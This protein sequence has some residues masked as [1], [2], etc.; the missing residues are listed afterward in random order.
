MI[1]DAHQHFWNG[2]I[3]DYPWLAREENAPI[4]R[5][6]DPSMLEPLL[7]D[8]GVDCTVVVQAMNSVKDTEAMLAYA[9][10][11][12]WI[13]G[14]VG[15]VPLDQPEVASRQLE[16]YVK[17]PQ[18]KGVRHLI[19]EEADP[20]WVVRNQ[21]IEGLQ[22]LASKGL[23]FDVVAV[24][25]HHLEH[26]P[27]LVNRI[28]TLRVVIDHLAKPPIRGGDFAAWK[29][30][31]AAA[32]ECP[33]VYAKVSG[34]NTAADWKSWTADDLLPWIDA[35]MELFGPERLMFGSD[36]PV[37]TLAGPY[38]QVWDATLAVIGRYGDAATR[39]ILGDTARHFYQLEER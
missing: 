12:P 27:T 8:V 14:V 17:H 30:E 37:A 26:V 11:Y 25:P 2:D 1:V 39:W 33:R 28:P 10:Q 9:E 21:V 22:V 16:G 31:M 36:W 34:L 19:H 5:A 15:W 35:A 7:K 24:Y 20:H 32:A 18:F 6:Y 13:A 23:P 3:A 4:C 38:R 29:R